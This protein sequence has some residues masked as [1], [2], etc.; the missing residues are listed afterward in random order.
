MYYLVDMRYEVKMSNKFDKIIRQMPSNARET[1]YRL[2]ERTSRHLVRYSPD[3]ITTAS[4][5]RIHIIAI[6]HINGLLA[7]G[8]RKEN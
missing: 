5:V 2:I 8:M 1:L 6:L 7:G 4:L 3:I